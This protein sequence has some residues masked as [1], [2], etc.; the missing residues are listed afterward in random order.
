MNA[1][2][3]LLRRH[4]LAALAAALL[5]S[6]CGGGGQDAS[7][8]VMP[9]EAPQAKALAVNAVTS[10]S[11][12]GLTKVSEKRIGRTLFEYEFRITVQNGAAAQTGLKAELTAAGPGTTI[13]Q[14]HVD[15]GDIAAGASLTPSGTITLRQDRLQAFQPSQLVWSFTA[16][17]AAPAAISLALNQGVIAAGDA[18]TVTP[19][20]TDAS[21]QALNPQP[22]V[23]LQVLM[24]AN[25][26]LGAAP[27]ISGNQVLTSADTRGGFELQ[28]TLGGLTAKVG[29]VV[30]ANNGQSANSG[31]FADLSANH[32]SI[33][34]N[35][36]L[37]RDA[38]A[39]GDNAAVATLKA[40]LADTSSHID[41]NTLYFGSAYAPDIGFVSDAAKLSAA[42][43]NPTP[44]DAAHA[45][46]LAQL[47]AKLAQITALLNST[48]GTDAENTALLVQY[49]AD[50]AAI[51]AQLKDPQAQPSA[52]GVVA[53]AALLNQLLTQDMPIAMRAMAQRAVSQAAV[54]MLSVQAPGA[55]SAAALAIKATAAP[56][57]AE[58]GAGPRALA[59]WPRATASGPQ[60]QFLLSG[61]L[62]A[63]GPIGKLIDGMYGQGLSQIQNMMTLLITKDLLDKLLTQTLVIEGVHAG[64]ALLG[65]YAY[66]YPDS[67]IELTNTSAAEMQGADAYL[68]G[69]SAVNALT[70]LG[71]SLQPPKEAKSFKEVFDYFKGIVDAIKS[72]GEAYEL[73]HQLPAQIVDNSFSENFGCLV[74][75]SDSCVEMQYPNGFKNVAG[76]ERFS[77]TVLILVRSG[78]PKPKYGSIVT[79]FAPST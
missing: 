47:Q 36:G 73:A 56:R 75:L 21:G 62:N 5:L 28:A 45:T 20:V 25:G 70:S 66:N 37:L 68:I 27:T 61:L 4:G 71:K 67:T 23:A 10:A 57:S 55:N 38:V 44:A 54:S 33:I 58:G 43:L 14:G 1:A 41:P 52:H 72:V 40:A 9:A 32:A 8:T 12:T 7:P 35:L 69:A 15:V 6:A 31:Q 24:P 76:G 51:A 79:N 50:L 39:R 11:V 48:T 17:G 30:V 59:A 16:S 49:Q 18:L 3:K 26:A 64:A 60:P 34:N 22:A 63:L 78:G 46:A 13:V 2:F 77:F 42:G 74:S 65:P 53:N 29:F 19:T